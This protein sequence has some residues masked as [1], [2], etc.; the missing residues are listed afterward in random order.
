MDPLG[1]LREFV[2]HVQSYVDWTEEDAALVQ[3]LRPAV[4]PHFSALV[5]DFYNAIR[6]HALTAGIVTGG[7]PQYD[8]LKRT[9][10][11]WLRSLFTGP[12][13]LEFATTRWRVGQRH[14]D[15]GLQQ[16]LAFAALARLRIGINQIVLASIWRQDARLQRALVAVN[17]LLDV[18][19]AIIDFAFQRASA[20]RL[21]L[22]AMRRVQQSER[23]AAIGQMVA[24]LAHESRNALQRSH[25]CLE[26]LKLDI[27]D[28]PDALKQAERI[29]S[30]LDRLHVLY[31]EV[32]NYAAPIKLD[33]EPTDVAALIRAVWSNLEARRTASS[34]RCE[35]HVEQSRPCLVQADRHRLDQVLTNLIQNALDAGSPTGRVQCSIRYDSQDRGCQIDIDDDGPGIPAEM[36]QQVFEPFFTTKTRGTGLGL[37][38]TKRIVEAHGGSIRVDQGPLGGARF[39]VVLPGS[40]GTSFFAEEVAAL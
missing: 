13:D 35:L 37:A 22:E 24:G 28:R 33:L 6:G 3:A 8:R 34:S 4:A 14:V 19:A 1:D 15:I 17:K 27:D 25:A 29:Q 7:E 38:I 5:E 16:A 39:T 31:E 32:R 20:H 18:D 9:L 2:E 12:Y 10:Q 26:A 30:A 21:Q 11:E 23:L 36:R 40:D